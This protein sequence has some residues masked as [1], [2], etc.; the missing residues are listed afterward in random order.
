M[1]SA[2]FGAEGDACVEC[3]DAAPAR[4]LPWRCP[5]CGGV[6]LLAPNGG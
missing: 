6:F 5:R 2:M 4:P 3:D 1:P